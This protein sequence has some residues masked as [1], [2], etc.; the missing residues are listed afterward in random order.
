MSIM[1]I[2]DRNYLNLTQICPIENLAE[3]LADEEK[4]ISN[5]AVRLQNY[6]SFV[7]TEHPHGEH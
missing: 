4:M 7:N 2:I 1:L 3:I 6:H 5:Q